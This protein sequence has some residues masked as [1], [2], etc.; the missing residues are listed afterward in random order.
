MVGRF[1]RRFLVLDPKFSIY[2]LLVCPMKKQK[3]KNKD[4]KWGKR[5]H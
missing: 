1:Y 5:D 2:F 4:Y 3:Q